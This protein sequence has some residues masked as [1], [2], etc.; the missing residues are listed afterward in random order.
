MTRFRN[1]TNHEAQIN[2]RKTMNRFFGITGFLAAGM[3]AIIASL[4][5]YGP[6]ISI[7]SSQR[8][9]GIS[10]WVW[11]QW[12]AVSAIGIGVVFAFVW[13]SLK[14]H[15]AALRSNAAM[16]PAAWRGVCGVYLSCSVVFALPLFSGDP[17]GTHRIEN[18]LYLCL[19]S[20]CLLLGALAAKRGICCKQNK[21]VP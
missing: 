10:V 3:T 19:A 18:Y 7:Y 2:P 13:C 21:S 11:I 16:S 6:W 1:G 12:G 9:P 15:W 5:A 4:I 20:C 17:S 8:A 14:S